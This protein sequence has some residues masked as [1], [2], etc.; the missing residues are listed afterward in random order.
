MAPTLRFS[1]LFLLAAS[2]MLAAGCGDDDAIVLPAGGAGQAGAGAHAGSSGSGAHAGGAGM[3]GSS[4][5]GSSAAGSSEA[6]GSGADTGGAAG[7][8]GA[9]PSSGGTSGGGTSGGGTSGGGT[10]GGGTGG[11]TAGGGGA[12][13]GTG[14]AAGGG[15]AAAGT[16]GTAGG[17]G[18]TAGSGGTAG[19]GG[20]TAG[21]GGTAGGGGAGNAVKNCAYSCATD[22]DCKITGEADQS[23]FCNP[24]SKRCEDFSVCATSADCVAFVNQFSWFTPCTGDSDCLPGAEACVAVGRGG[25]CAPLPDAQTG[26]MTGA[27]TPL[28][29]FGATGN[30]QVCADAGVCVNKTCHSLCDCSGTTTCNATTGLCDCS[31]NGQC[32]SQASQG[33][34]ICGAD[35]HCGCA[36][37]DQCNATASTGLDHCYSGTCGCS[38]ANACPDLHFS[39]APPVC[40]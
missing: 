28:A 5:A 4:A 20:A 15:G 36:T 23:H 3:A 30:V 24:T 40:E 37:S 17:G 6:G 12:T 8:G 38:S 19:G 26:C 13:A 7:E 9:P 2:W 33:R 18:A 31:S 14:G 11:A 27:P 21:T 32:T 35:S 25:L 16:S 1:S 22:D 39:N 34:P 10:S 29:H